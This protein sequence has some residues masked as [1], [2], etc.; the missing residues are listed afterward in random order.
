MSGVATQA[1]A[2][3]WRIGQHDGGL[4][5]FGPW[6][7]DSNFRVGRD[8]LTAFPAT[9]PG[10]FS[11]ATGHR[12]ASFSIEFD[13][14]ATRADAVE[15]RLEIYAGG[16]CPAIEF[17]LNGSIS[18]IHP[19]PRRDIGHGYLVPASP[20]AGWADVIAR[21]PAGVLRDGVNNLTL[22]TVSPIEFDPEEAL[23]AHPLAVGGASV[24]ITEVVL[25]ESTVDADPHIR[26]TPLP[27]YRHE[28]DGGGEL[29][30]VIVAV[31]E[32]DG[33]L[34][35]VLRV[36][37]AQV[38]VVFDPT[39]RGFGEVLARVEV[40]APAGSTSW[41]L[42]WDH[43]GTPRSET[44]EFKPCRQ[45][46]LH[47]V[48]HS[49]LD[50]GYTDHAPK[51]LD[52]HARN[53]D[54]AL[55][56]GAI[57]GTYSLALD[58]S[59]VAQRYLRER[60]AS[61]RDAFLERVRAGRISINALY[62]QFLTGTTS[63]AEWR[64]A[65]EFAMNLA[66]END[67]P[68]PV[69]NITDVPVYSSALPSMLV[70][71]GVTRF[72]GLA[73]HCRALTD[74]SDILHLR[75][76]FRWA[77]PDG[78]EVL[79]FFGNNYSQLADLAGRAWTLV[80]AT[81]TLTRLTALYERDEYLPDHLPVL[82]THSDND[83]LDPWSIAFVEA[84][85]QQFAFPRLEFGTFATYF[86]AVQPLLDDLPVVRGEGGAYWEEGL[87][88]L[89]RETSTYRRV[90]TALPAAEAAAV[91]ACLADERLDIDRAELSATWDRLLIAAD[92]TWTADNVA[93]LPDSAQS[94]GQMQWQRTGLRI[95]DQFAIDMSR[96]ALDK[97]AENVS[98]TAPC[99]I[100]VNPSSW[101]R[102]AEFEVEIRKPVR[103]THRG[104]PV[105]MA[106]VELDDGTVRA[107]VVGP[108]VPAF[109]YAVLDLEPTDEPELQI[110]T[111]D[112]APPLLRNPHWL[113][114]LWPAESG[115]TTLARLGLKPATESVISSTRW[116]VRVEAGRIRGIRHLGLGVELLDQASRWGF[117][118]V[119]RVV[120]GG[121]EQ[122]RGLGDEI[123]TLWSKDIGLRAP[124][125]SE[126]PGSY[127]VLGVRR[128]PWGL[129]VRIEGEAPTIPGVE[130]EI[131][132]RDDDDRI[133]VTVSLTKEHSLAKESVYVA[134]PFATGRRLRY[135]RQVG[136]VD[137]AED[138]LPGACFEWHSAQN[139]VLLDDDEAA[140]TWVPVDTPLFTA[141]DIARNAWPQRHEPASPAIF[142]WVMNNWWWT[143][144]PASQAGTLVA[145]YSMLV[146]RRADLAESARFA[147][148]RREPVLVGE[149]TPLDKRDHS[150][151]ALPSVAGTVLSVELSDGLV[152]S[153]ASAPDETGRALVHIVD[154]A[155]AGGIA[156]IAWKGSTHRCTAL[157]VRLER[158]PA[159][160]EAPVVVA[161]WGQ[162]TVRLDSDGR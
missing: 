119:F 72:V 109:G 142:S 124:E 156:T 122:G 36:G 81:D 65:C 102:T 76:P 54:R 51:A 10:P 64:R 27:L 141:G 16:A 108:K 93:A 118:E 69:A 53:I 2:E 101:E 162:V 60:S 133:D 29:V 22:R 12:P 68:E 13:R 121:T 138:F 154:V 92:H 11:A 158:L 35:A 55:R 87:G 131:L 38:P 95:A 14:P 143:N 48:P 45:W 128:L 62:A 147:R 25:T 112:A 31:P 1:A 73:N 97:L 129:A 41:T 77:G 110:S 44:G 8:G 84:W 19:S 42:E 71:S 33:A 103:L 148:E 52:I 47:V 153:L 9:I 155:G 82:G 146:R 5:Q 23:A 34:N 74:D 137:P 157:G 145:R 120:G 15:V 126:Q 94:V 3:L 58:G 91:L 136:W 57:A 83:D 39:G 32:W 113:M 100:V 26:V 106:A 6:R 28:H 4:A 56:D 105:P 89:A 18:R 151:R 134:F 135:E 152:A 150:P 59:I 115:V 160:G 30:D 88:A 161:P 104:E 98:T 132:L 46:T 117:A 107:R 24:G 123:T 85:N 43:Q 67:L 49:H 20:F 21:F 144:F 140:V 99:I 40:P 61:S 66:A 139:A 50:L 159:S 90:Q 130:T 116:E 70:A 125:L 17:D 7:P 63:L 37:E 86:D 114:G 127:R 78:S 111:V 75:S 80:G 79:A 149:V 96:S